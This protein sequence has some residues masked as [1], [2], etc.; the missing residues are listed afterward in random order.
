MCTRPNWDTYAYLS[1]RMLQQTAFNCLAEANRRWRLLGR[2]LG[3]LAG[4]NETIHRVA[5]D[6]AAL[7][8]RLRVDLRAEDGVVAVDDGL[9][10]E[11]I[12][13]LVADHSNVR[14]ARIHL[15]GGGECIVAD[16]EGRPR[17]DGQVTNVVVRGTG[18]IHERVE[19]IGDIGA[20]GEIIA[21]DLNAAA[22]A[23]AG[24]RKVERAA[25]S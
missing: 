5:P 13:D 7:E 12:K 2:L 11:G 16:A 6:N 8:Q 15:D 4:L 21:L 18:D 20:R 25:K 23:E 3:A 19:L 22:A 17:V 14:H 10:G 24:E 9:L 1:L